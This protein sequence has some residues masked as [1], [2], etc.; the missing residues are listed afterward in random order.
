MSSYYIRNN[1]LNNAKWQ[2]AARHNSGERPPFF[3]RLKSHFI[4]FF[5]N[6]DLETGVINS[7]YTLS[8]LRPIAANQINI[9]NLI[10][11]L[12]MSSSK[13]RSSLLLNIAQMIFN[14]SFQ[15]HLFFFHGTLQTLTDI[16]CVNC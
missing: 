14:I 3:C 13:V 8:K 4:L 11:T 1:L 10:L 12:S 2:P 9:L 15:R 16:T 5:F 7:N 6:E